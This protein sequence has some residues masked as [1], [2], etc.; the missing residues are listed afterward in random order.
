VTACLVGKGP[1]VR[2]SSALLPL[3]EH[4]F[5][6]SARSRIRPRVVR[7]AKGTMRI[8][9]LLPHSSCL[10]E[11][12]DEGSPLIEVNSRT[13][14]AALR[15]CLFLLRIANSFTAVLPATSTQTATPLKALSTSRVLMVRLRPGAMRAQRAAGAS[16]NFELP[17][18]S[19]A[20]RREK[21]S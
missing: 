17:P 2:G 18:L 1:H 14:S 8:E 6:R 5:A 20:S 4:R 16:T 7:R 11:F 3:L 21:R 10:A 19:G 12:D 13:R 9:P 15:R